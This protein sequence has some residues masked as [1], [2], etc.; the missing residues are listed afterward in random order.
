MTSHN[1][2]SNRHNMHR[3]EMTRAA[4]H[5][6][7]PNLFLNRHW[8]DWR[9]HDLCDI[10]DRFHIPRDPDSRRETKIEL[11][12]RLYFFVTRTPH[13]HNLPISLAELAIRFAAPMYL[14]PQI[15]SRIQVYWPYSTP[16]TA[17][18]DSG[19]A[20]NVFAN[21]MV[22]IFGV[23]SSGTRVENMTGVTGHALETRGPYFI[24]ISLQDSYG[25]TL[26][27]RL[28]FSSADIM[29]LGFHMILGMPWIVSQVGDINMRTRRWRFAENRL[30]VN[31]LFPMADQQE[32]DELEDGRDSDAYDADD[33]DTDEEE[34]D[35]EEEEEDEEMVKALRQLAERCEPEE[36]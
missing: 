29:G 25:R 20:Q 5:H 3:D 27:S 1:Y 11:A 6:G 12:A 34:E 14:Y 22:D 17:L 36:E 18:V 9:Y 13:Q 2:N 26:T 8:A 19:F 7:I 30:D 33:E 23:D 32:K 28:R 24:S 31:M 16:L 35:E 4:A 21:E 10:L 15:V